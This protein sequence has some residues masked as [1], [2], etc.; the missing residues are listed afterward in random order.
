MFGPHGYSINVQNDD[1]AR[2]NAQRL[3]A[4]LEDAAFTARDLDLW[5]DGLPAGETLRH[6]ANY[7]A[8]HAKEKP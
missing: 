8:H 3:A 4:I 6:L 2:E 1:F 5:L 7:V